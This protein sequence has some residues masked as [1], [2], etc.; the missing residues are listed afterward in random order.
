MCISDKAQWVCSPKCWL[1]KSGE[2]REYATQVA[3]IEETT[4]IHTWSACH[5]NT[6]HSAEPDRLAVTHMVNS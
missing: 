6:G 1:L 3:Q 2:I 5:D 4:R